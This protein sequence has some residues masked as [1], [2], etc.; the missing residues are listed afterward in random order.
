VSTEQAAALMAA[1][2]PDGSAALPDSSLAAIAPTITKNL[3]SNASF[4]AIHQAQVPLHWLCTHLQRVMFASCCLP[5]SCDV[6]KIYQTCFTVKEEIAGRVAAVFH[7]RA[8]I[9]KFTNAD[10]AAVFSSADGKTQFL[11]EVAFLPDVPACKQY[12]LPC[13]RLCCSGRLLRTHCSHHAGQQSQ[14]PL[15]RCLVG[16]RPRQSCGWSGRQSC[17][18]ESS[19]SCSC[20]CRMTALC[21]S[22]YIR[23]RVLPSHVQ[24]PLLAGGRVNVFMRSSH[25]Y[26][27]NLDIEL[28]HYGFTNKLFMYV[29]LVPRRSLV[30]TLGHC[31]SSGGMY[32][33][34]A[35]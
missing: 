23:G 4:R 12:Q 21:A 13:Q 16:R 17:W 25:S 26:A 10:G 28:Y 34:L 35:S 19:C 30:M 9:T 29:N 5:T 31:A 22:L 27:P 20:T 14:Q 8:A 1:A 11:T 24:G 7:L 6:Q 15:C 18:C 2:V 3:Q 33:Y 32:I